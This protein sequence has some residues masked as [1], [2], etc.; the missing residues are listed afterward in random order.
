MDLH[1][2]WRARKKLGEFNKE[3]ENFN[4][5]EYPVRLAQGDE[6]D[7]IRRFLATTYQDRHIVSDDMIDPATEML[8][9]GIEVGLDR[10]EFFYVPGTEGRQIDAAARLI[11]ASPY[12]GVYSLQMHVDELPID[13]RKMVEA[14]PWD[15]T[16]ECGSLVKAPGVKTTVVMHLIREMF[17][18][19]ATHDIKY[20][21]WGME[22]PIAN[23]YRRMFGDIITRLGPPVSFGEFNFQHV[24]QLLDVQYGVERFSNPKLL[25]RV[26]GKA[27]LFEF[28]NKPGGES[29]AQT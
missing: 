28:M 23:S 16:V 17:H 20:W 19:S 14:L 6:I 13:S 2:A 21:V 29:V 15:Q 10:S 8:R 25:E 27:A 9:E 26:M 1:E 12:E 22:D 24:P 18:Y 3:L 11:H 7:A 4:T 5:T